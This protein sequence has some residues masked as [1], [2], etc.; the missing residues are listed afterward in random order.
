MAVFLLLIVFLLIAPRAGNAVAPSMAPVAS[1]T[2]A[3][4]LSGPSA[5][6]DLS[7]LSVPAPEP[8]P[9]SREVLVRFKDGVTVCADALFRSGKPFQAATADRSSSL[10]LLFRQLRVRDVRAVFRPSCESLL[11]VAELRLRETAAVAGSLRGAPGRSGREGLAASAAPALYHV[12]RIELGTGVDPDAAAAALRR[13]P[14]VDFAEPNRLAVTEALPNDRYVDPG[15]KNVFQSGSWA[16]PYADLWG[17]DRIG[18]GQVWRRQAQIWPDPARRGGG[19]VIVAVIDTG[20]D[21]G[22]PD[23]AANLWRDAAGNP[24]TDLVDVSNETLSALAAAGFSIRSEEDYRD[25]DGDPV[26]RNGHGTHVAGTIGAVARNGQGIAGVAWRAKI[27]PVRAGFDIF[28]ASD[29]MHLGAFEEDD[30][31]AAIRWAADHGADVINMSFGV[32]GKESSTLALALEYAA[33]LGV[34]LVAAAGNDG[35]DGADTWPAADPR[36]VSVGATVASD[37]RIFFSNWGGSVDIAAPGSEILSTRAAS[38][39]VGGASGVV[40]ARYTRASGTS[41]AAPHV[42]GAVALVLSAW[43]RLSPAE[44]V[45]RVIATAD[46]LP[47]EASNGRFQTL[48]SGRLNLLRALTAPARPTFILRSWEGVAGPGET[49]RLR[50]DLENAWLPVQGVTVNLVSDGPQATVL[51]GALP[52]QAWPSRRAGTMAVELRVA[53]D[54]AWG[55]SGPLHLEVRGAG[56]HQDLPFPLVLRGPAVK[57]GWPA[58]GE[59]DS[60]GMITS[61]ALGDLD[62]NGDLEI[63][64]LSS[65]GD[66]FLREADG[67]LVPGWPVTFHGNVEQSSPLVEDLDHNGQP[68]LVFVRDRKLHVM[69]VSGRELPGWPQEIGGWVLS[70]PA[71]GDVDGDGRDEIVVVSDDAQVYVFD[72]AGRRLPGWPRKVGTSSNTGPTLVDLDGKP[73]LEILAGTSDGLLVA[74]RA[75]G[76]APAGSWPAHLGSLGPSSPAVADLDGDGAVDIVAASVTGRLYRLDRSGRVT[77]LGKLP[78]TWAFSSPALGDLDGDGRLE[79]A[80]GSGQFDGSGFFSV[81]DGEG[82]LLPGWPVATEV[83]VAASPAL[84][85]LDGDKRPEV[86]VPD[87]GGGLHVWKAGGQALGGWPYNLAGGTVAAP[88]VADLDGDGTLEIVIGKTPPGAAGQPAHLLEALEFGS[89]GGG[90]GWPTYQGNPRRTGANQ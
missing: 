13:D 57:A 60:D 74:L 46:P 90:P 67:S 25:P 10:D 33:S 69:N 4:G 58:A 88:V 83:A 63:F 34:V 1:S 55:A 24:G 2:G 50:I 42:A 38:T 28:R 9:V 45:A 48:G 20:V 51:S 5:L 26:D 6:S 14:H 84:A 76:T 31:A 73:G 70:S 71:A 79:I 37:R 19:G 75:D 47:F 86:I 15:R 41:M 30:I 12:Y 89:A 78:G 87:L 32:R 56:V 29:G 8:L 22:H 39:A 21:A 65:R 54:V 85:D 59:Q 18:W 11:P 40:D 80:I 82:R 62:G 61:P 36:V 49:A 64:A 53:D 43:P 17:L 35:V 23:L 52:I 7:A 44:A 68:E 77:D 3:A 27:M 72:A 66:A 16:E 81:V